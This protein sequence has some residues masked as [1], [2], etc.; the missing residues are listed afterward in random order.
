MTPGRSD[1]IIPVLVQFLRLRIFAG[2]GSGLFGDSAL[3]FTE[4]LRTIC[5][6]EGTVGQVPLI[7]RGQNREDVLVIHCIH[8]T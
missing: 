5:Q 1:V 8:R 3:C 6:S 7:E 2:G 4:P